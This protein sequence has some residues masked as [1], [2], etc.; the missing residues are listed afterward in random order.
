MHSTN[1][2]AAVLVGIL[3]IQTAVS[4]HINCTSAQR[5]SIAKQIPAAYNL[6]TPAESAAAFEKVPFA[7]N[8]SVVIVTPEL[9]ATTV[10]TN[11]TATLAFADATRLAFEHV[12]GT[13]KDFANGTTVIFADVVSTIVK[14]VPVASDK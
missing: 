8:S 6:P 7:A 12:S 10:A 9:P 11:R 3:Y 13:Y 1:L 4:H 14:F 5:I 2:F